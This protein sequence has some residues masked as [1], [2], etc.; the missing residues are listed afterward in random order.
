VAI[1]KL[2]RAAIAKLR[3]RLKGATQLVYD[4]DNALVIGFVPT[5]RP[6]D[7]VLSIALY[8]RVGHDVLHARRAAARSDGPARGRRQAGPCDGRVS[9]TA[10]GSSRIIPI[11]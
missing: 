5:D 1:A 4:N 11:G 3:K 9:T 8:P 2:A 7:V 6:S 10:S